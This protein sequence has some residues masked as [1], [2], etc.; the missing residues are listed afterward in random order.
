METTYQK[1]IKSK[2]LRKVKRSQ[3]LFR[4]YLLCRYAHLYSY[5]YLNSCLLKHG[6]DYLRA[7]NMSDMMNA[8]FGENSTPADFIH[9]EDIIANRCIDI[10]E[11]MKSLEKCLTVMKIDP[12]DVYAFCKEVEHGNKL[13]FFKSHGLMACYILQDFKDYD[14][15]IISKDELEYKMNVL[16][17]FKYA[18]GIK[19]SVIRKL[20]KQVDELFIQICLKRNL[21]KIKKIKNGKIN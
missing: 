17:N 18:F 19:P 2:N 15:G 16:F 8:V 21:R 4:Y 1:T 13:F 9:N 3:R 14:L 11:E 7:E 5:R 12:Q 20:I 6:N 10:T